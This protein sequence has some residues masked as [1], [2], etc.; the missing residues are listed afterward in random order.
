MISTKEFW[1]KQFESEAPL[2][3]IPTDLPRPLILTSNKQTIVKSIPST[4]ALELKKTGIENVSNLFLSSL[5][6]ILHRY[7]GQEDIIIGLIENGDSKNAIPVRTYF[8]STDTF[9]ALLNQT[10]N[11]L[12]EIAPYKSFGL[13]EII[14]S[15]QLSTDTSRNPLFDVTLKVISSNQ[16][17]NSETNTAL[18]VDIAFE[19]EETPAGFDLKLTYNS[20]IYEEKMI[21][22]FAAH[23]ANLLQEI[24]VAPN[25]NICEYTIQS[26]P[27][28][29]YQ[30]TGLNEGNK[31]YP[32]E[33]TITSLF[34]EQ[35]ARTPNN[36]ALTHEDK[37]FTYTELNEISNQL[38]AYLKETY[39]IQTDDLVGI[40]LERGEWM[41]FAILGIL[42]SGGA[43]VPIDPE[44]P[45]D[46]IEYIVS[47]SK[48][49]V[50]IDSAFVES[51][52]QVKD[53]YSTLNPGLP[54]L[55][56]SLVY[57]IYTSGTTGKPKGSMLE[58]RNVVSLF[59]PEE[60]L[61][62]FNEK[63]VWTIFHSYS[64]DFSVW[65]MYGAFL[66]GGRAIV[67]PKKIAQDT[68]EFVNLMEREGVTILN[69]TPSAF[70]NV[71][72]AVDRRLDTPKLVLRIV[73]F[74]GEA[75][76][77]NRL[78]TFYK[79]YPSTQLIN[80]YGIT[81]TTV[82]VTYK[83][84]GEEEIQN[85]ISNIGI[86][87]PT[88]TCY[89]LDKHKQL[90]LQGAAGELYVG[91]AGLGRG[92]LNRPDLT[93][94]KFSD[95]P[96]INGE[97]LYKSG[98]LARLMEDGTIE[99][100]GRIDDQVKIRG[101]R[102]ELAEIETLLTQHEK[103]TAAVVIAKVI[104]GTDKDLVAY[105]TGDIDIKALKIYL[106]A[107]LPH[108]MV[109]RFFIKLDSIPLTVN[110]K[111][112]R[113]A[114]PMPE[115]KRPDIGIPYEA[116]RKNTEEL[117]SKLWSHILCVEP[118]GIKDN[119]FDFGGN[120][121]LAILMISRL[122]NE[123]KIKVPIVKIYQYPTIETFAESI[124]GT[125]A[126][127]L[128][129]GME[130]RAKGRNSKGN[131]LNDSVA[132]IGMSLKF[133]GVDSPEE[134]WKM[135]LEGRE[136]VSFFDDNTLDPSIPAEERND[137][138]YVRARGILKDVGGFDAGFF[139]MNPNVAKVTDPQLRVLLELSWNALEHAGHSPSY[140]GLI[141]VFQGTGQNTYYENNVLSNRDA[142]NKVGS[143]ITRTQNDK[144]FIATKVAYELN[145]KGVALSIYTACSTSLTAIVQACETLINRQC[146]MA[147]AGGAAIT[148]PV[149]SGQRYEEGAMFS[150]DGHTRTFD[151]NARGTVFSDGAGVVVLK[152]YEDAVKDGDTVYAVIRGGAL[153]NDGGEKGSFTAP[154]VSGQAAVISMAQAISSVNP[155][156]ISYVETHGTATP[157]GDPI[158]IEGLTRAFREYTDDKQFCAVG[159]VKT[160]FG[161]LTAAA[162]V[163]G[164]IKTALSLYYK[165]LPASIHF[166][167]P[168][169]Q[170]PFA[171]S[172]F[173]VN[174]SLRN[175]E[176]DQLPRR[177]AVSSFGVGGTN[178]HAILEEAP[179]RTNSGPSRSKQ[180]LLLS[181]KTETALQQRIE[182]LASYL[183]SNPTIPLGDVSYT[184]Q[185]GRQHFNHRFFAS[186]ENH[187]DALNLLKNGDP[188]RSNKY[189]LDKKSSGVVF[190]FPGQGS[191]Y[192]G[193]GSNLYRDEVVF[194]ES[195]D[196]CA[197]ILKPLLERDIRELLFAEEGNV[198][199]ENLLKQTYFTQPALFT[200]GYS[201]A[202]L[203]MSWGIQP[204]ALIG[205]SVG[206][207]VAATIAG[208]FSL[209][210]ALTAV[211]NRSRLMQNLPGGGML[212][213][214]LSAE[215]IEKYLS[216]DISIAAING[217]KLCVVAGPFDSLE[218]L[219]KEFESKEILC[220]ALHTS[221][222]FHSPMM[223]PIVEPFRDI[224]SGLK[225][226]TPTIPILSTVTTKWM[227]E[228]EACDPSYWASHLRATVKFADGVK[229]IWNDK[230]N[231]TLLELGPRN[232]ASTLALQQSSDTKSQKAIPTLGDTAK[233]DTE[234]ITTLAAVGQLWLSGIEIDQ[235]AFYAFE[236]R[237]RVALPTY[238]FEHKEYWLPIRSLNYSSSDNIIATENNIQEATLIEQQENTFVPMS[239]RKE[240][241]ISEIKEILEN[242][243]GIEME[244]AD[245]SSTFI[246]L[247]LD[248]L[249]LTSVALT[250]TKKYG[251]KTTFR[252]LNE[253]L[254]S[255]NSLSG[256]IDSQLPA[257]AEKP[258]S[259]PINTKSQSFPFAD[260]PVMHMQ[261][262][263]MMQQPV[264]LNNDMQ[265]LISQQLQL[266]QQQLM[267][268]QGQAIAPQSMSSQVAATKPAI[269]N[270]SASTLKVD[271][272][273]DISTE[274]LTELKKPFGAVARIEKKT[275][276]QFNAKQQ[277]WLEVFTTAYNEKTKKSKAY[278]QQHRKH[279]ADPRVV[280]GF[281]PHLKEL[282]Y[283]PVV[284]RSHGSRVW[285][286]DGNEYVD[287]LNGFGSNMFGHSPDFIVKAID[288]QLK[289]G[290]EA[291]PQHE[292]AGEVAELFCKLTGADRVGLCSTGS[293][294]VLGAMRIARTITGRSLI[295]SFNGSYHGIIDEVIVRGSKKLKSVPAAA[296][297]MPESVLNMLVLDYG[298]PETLE[299]IKS[300]ASEIA[301][302]LVE[303]VQS[304]RADFQ[305]REFL[306]D[307]RKLTTETGS[308]LI[309]DEIITG[310]R[311]LPGGAQ[312]YFD[313]KADIGTFG[314][315]VGGGMPIG[316][317]AGKREY[318]DALDGG[319]WQ[320]GDGSIPEI[321]V[322]Y[323][324]GTFVR[325]PFAL[326]AA[327]A[328]LQHLIEK[329]SALQEGLTASTSY[330]VAEM[331][332]YCKKLEV[333]MHFVQFASLFKPKYEL[334]M[335]NADLLYL[336]LRYKGIHVYD[337]FP[338]FLTEG[339][340]S[341]D[342]ETIIAKFK[343][344][345]R[346]L[347]EL[348]FIPGTIPSDEVIATNGSGHAKIEDI[349]P[350]VPGALL[351]KNP[352]GSAGWFLPDPERPGKY[353]KVN[354]N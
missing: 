168:N 52:L 234:W 119:F 12:Q 132:I 290:Y 159:S 109:P 92:Y 241:I 236:E 240:N 51:F 189:K 39:T 346:E 299:I 61:Y 133:P 72:E 199:A 74:G 315:V 41:I 37:H 273:K 324:A 333:P 248:S 197:E 113:K 220:K 45:Q 160:N 146:D 108:F 155:R 195:V 309:F 280:T 227:T 165:T 162:G 272:T 67:V 330:I 177:A 191:Q 282:I 1:L 310:F 295:V 31:G 320:Y 123:H 179:V 19:I 173:F 203:W 55:P 303:P 259:T 213:V 63:D 246:E 254:S 193:M 24:I 32:T 20:D 135:L 316:V 261:L 337:G 148:S 87:I 93:A 312:Q 263:Q 313:V 98:D 289:R 287:I 338:C 257:E 186:V 269:L 217:P 243:S 118:I 171:D 167:A 322:T 149:N 348:G 40:H 262:P 265:S 2:L 335:P 27:E 222:A 139:N 65:E 284:N 201:L 221:H 296:G 90:C 158:E 347:V 112:N 260:S 318:M 210:D 66:F 110:G 157:L 185:N 350:P 212:S 141:G 143:F 111:V 301:A 323:F 306:H 80:M 293:E 68:P 53:N 11:K 343:E 174:H 314:K 336:L 42:K 281:K 35:V 283:Q 147:L 21:V 127:E 326:A 46:R 207:F 145:L 249:F 182:N 300:R 69:Q 17:N 116:P 183:E 8:N 353:L 340:T 205:H 136:T 129:Q 202:Q 200:I 125:N 89:I 86:P 13:Q 9:S 321:G 327:K 277:R 161:H 233:N 50:L 33:K 223:D 15:L 77:P 16:N 104:T 218:K 140:K 247:G 308:L 101:Y 256:Y 235:K 298:T 122:Q 253:E 196:Q 163:A 5:N 344:A 172:P 170:I 144:D 128:K 334:D 30:L 38:G 44:Y 156:T 319:H 106:A 23:Y 56:N 245:P 25:K 305:P 91:G 206:E 215:E 264:Q 71:T 138:N 47:D 142:I 354:Q 94:D 230:P 105:L 28:I 22:R 204:A 242:A 351:G 57:V 95:H 274:E 181:A 328:S 267:M 152:R 244:Q 97:R 83:Y 285:D 214:R 224:I 49:K 251:V 270:N 226:N 332:N 18:N 26:E 88:L 216:A 275:N 190:M 180:L 279:L 137:P 70:Y 124:S 304:R 225:L 192:V 60:Q 85:G 121:Y 331:N 54:I 79:K 175:W 36:I 211:A 59:F 291:G 311:I 115:T 271:N 103:V 81:E 7:T 292:L 73:I 14:N 258:A 10:K 317:I 198:D 297:I 154:S 288:E 238:P 117:L 194:R 349:M 48:C 100:L 239:N 169:P 3:E 76:H 62:D 82:F 307:L 187:Q 34:E 29:A 130:A 329:G 276:S 294:A 64:F 4:V 166:T 341:E 84:I 232:T 352:D 75:L 176:T 188:K 268:M 102:I 153:N 286:I 255:L 178:A 107:K 302:V 99:Y 151:I 209:N 278:T 342:L 231:Y 229:A 164:I 219:Q 345:L 184:L 58:H 237:Y 339:H 96:T 150:N 131:S 134:F 114:L 78:S 228:T 208:V 250:I 325:H 252:Q 43:Y 266:M 120:S 6:V 126:N